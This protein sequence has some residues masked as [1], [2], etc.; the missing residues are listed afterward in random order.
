MTHDRM[1]LANHQVFDKEPVFGS[2]SLRLTMLNLRPSEILFFIVAGGLG[3]NY[4]THERLCDM[5]AML[6]FSLQPSRRP[7]Q[8]E[9]SPSPVS[10]T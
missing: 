2:D 5:R 9:E 6:S 7:D 1:L 10:S 4:V 8:L 3:A